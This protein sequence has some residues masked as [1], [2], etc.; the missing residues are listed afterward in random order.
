MPDNINRMWAEVYSPLGVFLGQ[1]ND[2]IDADNTK[3]LDGVGS[4]SLTLTGTIEE[5]F[6][7][8][9]A[10]NRALIYIQE[11]TDSRLFGGGIVRSVKVSDE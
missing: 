5:D 4:F 2:I 7:L 3:F 8:L 11:F 6:T 10:G 1:V 9:V